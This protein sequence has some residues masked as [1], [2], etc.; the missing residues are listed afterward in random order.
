MTDG[1]ANFTRETN[2]YVKRETK[3]IFDKI[4]MER[5]RDRKSNYSCV[6]L[7]KSELCDHIFFFLLVA[8]RRGLCI[9]NG[10]IRSRDGKGGSLEMLEI[11]I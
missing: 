11:T 8:G 5:G 4:K 1:N 2:N 9:N 3:N 10:K 6:S 7:N